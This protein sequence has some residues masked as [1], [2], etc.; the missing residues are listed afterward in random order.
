MD[1]EN[2]LGEKV[3][4]SN[5]KEYWSEKTLE[6]YK[7]NGRYERFLVEEEPDSFRYCKLAEE[8]K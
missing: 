7:T 6:Y 2:K 1:W 3:M 5:N 4:V 8:E